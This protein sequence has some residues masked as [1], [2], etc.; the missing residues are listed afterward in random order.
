[1]FATIAPE[2]AGIEAKCVQEFLRIVRDHEI[3]LHSAIMLRGREV[4]F[5]R[6]WAPFDITRAHRMY[7]ITKSFVAVA[8]GCLVQDGVLRLD[9]RIV[10]FFPDKLP[11]EVHPWLEAQTVGDMLT[12]RTCFAGANWFRPEVTDRTRFYFS[13]T[14]ARPAGTLFHY[15]STGSYILGVLVERLS[16]MPLLDYLKSE[17]LDHIGGF[18]NAEILKT[19]DGTPWGD[20]ALLC[21]PRALL[22]F[23]RFVM[24]LGTWDGERLLGEDYLRAATARQTDNN[25][26]GRMDYNR[27]G[28]GYQIWKTQQDGFS[29]NGMG[30]QF[31]ICVPRKDFIFVCTGDNQLNSAITSPILF[32]TVFEQIANHL[33]GETSPAEPPAEEEPK[34]PVAHGATHS[35]FA[36]KIDGAWFACESNPMGIRRFRLQFHDGEDACLSYENGQGRKDLRFGMKHNCFGKFPQSGY[37]DSHGNVHEHTGFRYDCAASAGWIEERKLQ[38]RVQIIDRYFGNLVVTFGFLNPQVAGLRMMK[39]AEDF[40]GKYQGWAGARRE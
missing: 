9:D 17:V 22:R 21:T 39:C 40:L 37:S 10:T 1:M 19:P 16:G 28:Y 7:S 35:G 31:A 38:L 27:H 30:G 6:Y 15:D 25:L 36:E 4:F 12:M 29:F 14:P 33:P 11:A 23:A 32:R 13:G 34:L 18:D 5:E 20:S 24:N 3:N 26:E 2:Q 8:V